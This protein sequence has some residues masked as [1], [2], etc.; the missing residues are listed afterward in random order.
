MITLNYTIA[1]QEYKD[2]YY[3][4][5]WLAPDKKAYRIKYFLSAFVT[6]LGVVV[7]LFIF[8]KN[9]RIDSIT[10]IIT[11]LVSVTLYFYINFSM[12]RHFYNYGKKIYNESGGDV[13][14]MTI[15]ETGVF[16]KNNDGEGQYKWSA[17]SKKL[18]ANGCIYLYLNS[19]QA[20]IFP[21]RIFKSSIE[22]DTFEKMLAQYLPLQ[23]NLAS[24]NK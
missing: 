23:A 18:E 24:L 12:K 14:E 6:Y 15:G 4:S 17:F 3:F 8:N 5:G 13:I 19:S 16:G 7:L 11:L 22:K 21:N 9:S 2:F 1:E 20:L 10:V